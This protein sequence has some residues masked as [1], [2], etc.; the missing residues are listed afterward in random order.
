[1]KHDEHKDE[2]IYRDFYASNNSEIDEQNSYFN[3]ELRSIVNDFFREM[4]LS[5]NFEL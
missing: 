5:R 2:V 4:T 3:E 1:M